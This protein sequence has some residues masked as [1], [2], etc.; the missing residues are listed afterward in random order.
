[1]QHNFVDTDFGGH[2]WNEELAEALMAAYDSPTG[3]SAYQ[4]IK[5]MISH[6]GD[7][8]TRLVA[9]RYYQQLLTGSRFSHSAADREGRLN[10]SLK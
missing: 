2:D 8:Y 10:R 5:N 4:E 6:L 3:D 7:P 9:P 1:M